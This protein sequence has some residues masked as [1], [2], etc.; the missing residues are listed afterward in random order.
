MS[1][2]YKLLFTAAAVAAALSIDAAVAKDWTHV[3]VG[4]EGVFP[5]YSE[6][7]PDGKL[8]GWD[9]ELTT[10]LCKRAKVECEFV[11]TDFSALIPGLLA[12]KTD[13]VASMG[14]TAK[15]RET[16]ELTIP[17]SLFLSSFVIRKGGG[18]AEFPA[19]GERLNLDDKE[20]GDRFMADARVK[21]KGKSVGV[22]QATSFNRV[23][24]SY[25]GDD[26]AIREYKDAQ[27]RDLDLKAGRIDA[28][29]DSSVYE[30]LLLK[31]SGNGDLI[32]TG[33][34]IGGGGL[35]SELGLA[36]RKDD[37]DLKVMFD[38]AIRLAME[39]GTIRQL[40]LKYTGL[41][42]SPVLPSEK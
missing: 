37:P 6:I 12:G 23:L 4:V 20:K 32:M 19:T 5:P 39:D 35:V 11:P 28:G 21:F 16:A 36:M 7:G 3:K 26:V 25:F 31:K 14:I 15:R 33:P 24:K 27:D 40:S 8:K 22:V 42:L 13:A 10:E 2:K 9:I 38:K 30:A 18:V 34:M 1:M 17:Y 41:D 29:F